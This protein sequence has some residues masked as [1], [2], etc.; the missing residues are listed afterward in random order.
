MTVSSPETVNH[1]MDTLD[2]MRAFVRV[3]EARSFTR[4]AD[5][6]GCAKA[7]VT[8]L[9]SALEHQ[10]GTRLLQRTTR[11]VSPT[12]EGEIYLRHCQHLLP[13]VDA[14]AA[15]INPQRE[16]LQ[17][18]I[19]CEVPSSL[20]RSPLIRRLAAFREQAPQVELLFSC[21][22]RKAGLV[23]EGLDC[24]IRF[25]KLPDSDYVAR[26]L[27]PARIVLC[28]T[29]RYLAR[30]AP[31]TEPDN[32][33]AHPVIDYFVPG[34][35]APEVWPLYSEHSLHHVPVQRAV[36]FDDDNLLL[37]AGLAGLG[38][39]QSPLHLVAPYIASGQLER[40]LPAWHLRDWPMHLLTP[41][42]QFLSP[43]VRAFCNWV[44]TELGPPDGLN[45]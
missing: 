36:A 40:V 5:Q 34:S 9:V 32:L 1:G 39:F 11:Y 37:E 35:T 24:A 29:P 8:K 16:R 23:R 12:P 26:P 7:T 2:A 42:P 41:R 22:D 25:G 43:R 21:S 15:A 45:R 33:L 44:M 10:L 17:G 13:Q 14:A 20:A 3:A 6:L 18:R 19:W 31:V 30:H 28:A 38:I 27:C 4:A